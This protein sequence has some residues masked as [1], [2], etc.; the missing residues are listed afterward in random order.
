MD[1]REILRQAQLLFVEG[2]VKESAEAFAKALEAGADPYIAHL[3]RGVAYVKLKEVDNALSDFSKAISVNDKSAR[4]YFF[5][6]M[7]YMMKVE[8]ENAIADFTK[9]L[10]LKTDHG[11]AK[12]ARGVSYARL[13]RFEESSKDMLAVL[14]QMEANLQSFADTYGIVRTEMW[15]VMAQTT[16]EEGTGM[17]TLELNEKDRKTLE[18]WLKQEE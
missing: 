5:R 9:T 15:K 4:A 13:E 17:S 2:K 14:P 6:G 16:E 12:F 3:S 10:E 1:P 18:K 11:M 8:Y 7:T